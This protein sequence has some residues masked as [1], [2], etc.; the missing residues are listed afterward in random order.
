MSTI[1]III[2]DRMRA[3]I[4]LGSITF[5]LSFFLCVSERSF[6]QENIGKG[7]LFPPAIVTE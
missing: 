3:P 4:C 7:F 5:V 6:P 1:I 2:R